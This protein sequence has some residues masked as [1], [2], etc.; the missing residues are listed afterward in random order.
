M[1]L[2]EDARTHTDCVS[3]VSS[4]I[5][6][7]VC[8]HSR[9]LI[10]LHYTR[11][12]LPFSPPPQPALSK[13][14]WIFVFY[15]FSKTVSWWLILWLVRTGNWSEDCQSQVQVLVLVQRRP[16]ST[17]IW[18]GY[19]SFIVS[20]APRQQEDYEGGTW[21]NCVALIK[22]KTQQSAGNSSRRW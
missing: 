19:S 17:E 1:W 10:R 14:L 15:A 2:F 18:T 20:F 7:P 12:L 5:I 8:L 21:L 11:F 9:S 4:R 22:C 3:S 16:G 6:L 13:G